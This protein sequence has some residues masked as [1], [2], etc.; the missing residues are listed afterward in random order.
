ME[1]Q[2]FRT[3][4]LLAHGAQSGGAADLLLGKYRRAVL[5][6]LYLGP[7]GAGWRL[8]QLARETGMSPGTVQ[9]ELRLLVAAG[10]VVEDRGGDFPRYRPDP[11]SALH[12]PLREFLGSLNDVAPVPAASGGA[13]R[14]AK[15]DRVSLLLHLAYAR[16]IRGN[17][18]LF[19]KAFRNIERWQRENAFP[20]PYLEEWLG[21]LRQGMERTLAFMVSDTEEAR[22]L[23]Q[24]SP[25]AG[26]LTP[27]ERWE[28]MKHAKRAA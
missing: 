12:A 3:P 14:H 17:P 20:Q 16:K 25:F 10:L 1:S 19:D 24:S 11:A 4:T 5:T 21:I 22:R 23:R 28:L 7:P 26:V 2:S 27:K 8:R 15:L 6:R 13:H 18:A 9:R